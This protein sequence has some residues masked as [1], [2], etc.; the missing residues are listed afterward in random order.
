MIASPRLH[1]TLS[2][3]SPS[4][5]LGAS[6]GGSAFKKHTRLAAE[7]QAVREVLNT[8]GAAGPP[9]W[10]RAPAEGLR[11][12]HHGHGDTA[13]LVYCVTAWVRACSGAR[14]DDGGGE[15]GQAPRL[16]DERRRR[17]GARL[18][19]V[20]THARTTLQPP[21]A[22][23]ARSVSACASRLP[24]LGCEGAEGRRARAAH[25]CL[26]MMVDPHTCI[27]KRF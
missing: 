21:L 12:Q 23:S 14:G 9:P 27:I 24:P 7:I 26:V 22:D 2:P 6:E 11:A 15:E 13:F 20:H 1:S 8:R 17:R 18:T 5:S 25:P 3:W 4:C 16:P 10:L 19:H